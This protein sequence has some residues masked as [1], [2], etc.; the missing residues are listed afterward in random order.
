M[1]RT[2]TRKVTIV[3]FGQVIDWGKQSIVVGVGRQ[4]TLEECSKWANEGRFEDCLRASQR[5]ADLP[6]GET[7]RLEFESRNF[8]QGIISLEDDTSWDV[9]KEGSMII[10]ETP[11][12]YQ[13]FQV[14][15]ECKWG[16]GLLKSRL[17]FLTSKKHKQNYKQHGTIT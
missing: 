8:Q 6:F 1:A 10:Q 17:C 5:A 2:V 3:L 9:V 13:D 7:D 15:V 16:S 4:Y 11:S 14:Q 12:R